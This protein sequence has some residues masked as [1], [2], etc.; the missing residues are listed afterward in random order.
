MAKASQGQAT[1]YPATLYAPP[2]MP[3]LSRL[4]ERRR[5]SAPAL[6]AFFNMMEKWQVRDED[7]RQL[8][9][10]ISNGAYYQLKQSPQRALEQDRLTRISYLVG[11]FKALNILY[12]P[13]LADKWVQL[14]NSNPIFGGRTPLAYM[15]QGGTPAME[16][17][18]RLLDARR[19]G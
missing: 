4:E 15:L 12:G 7:A 5:L 2:A 3:D 9:G 1:N 19:G 10:G 14:E 18:R 11:I 17:V 8:L 6:R 13:R 16:V